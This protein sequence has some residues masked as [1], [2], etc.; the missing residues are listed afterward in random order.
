MDSYSE[1]FL[2][3]NKICEKQKINIESSNEYIIAQL[4]VPNDF[5][6]NVVVNAQGKIDEENGRNN[7]YTSHTGDNA[8]KQEGIIFNI[9]P[10]NQN[11]PTTIPV[12]CEAW[13]DGC[14]TCRVDNGQIS[15]CTRMMC[16]TT[17]TP[18]C[19]RFGA[20]GH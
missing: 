5:S 16:F 1:I 14:N 2:E 7:I 4:T 6:Y 17:D 8:W 15:G 3:I 13:Y 19:L 12:N 11:N 18:Y 20:T 10:P 9:A